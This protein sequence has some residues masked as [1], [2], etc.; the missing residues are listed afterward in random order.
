MSIDWN[1]TLI[2]CHRLGDIMTPA[3]NKGETLSQ[4]C[5]SYL[6]QLYRE[7][8]YNRR[9]SI[10]SKYI[11]KGL[12]VEED[13]ITLYARVKH[14]MY[15]KNEERLRNEF[16]TGEPDSYEGEEIRKATVIL[17][18]K[19]VWDLFTLPYPDDK[20]DS[21]YYWQGQGY[22]DLTGAEMFKLAYCL[23]DTPD[24]L[25]QKEIDSIRWR[26]GVEATQE[27]HEK[28]MKAMRYSDIPINERVVE[29]EI[30]HDDEAINKM[31]ERVFVCRDYL[32]FL[33]TPKIIS[34]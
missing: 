30:K 26:T 11:E 17:D 15:K 8:K 19:S 5:K 27:Q 4:T 3:K 7:K 21:G 12:H 34:V 22:M 13:S 10:I 23:V 20:I 28:I 6:R 1:Q 32:Q 18:T 29:F 14:R 25:I 9:K 33:D 24:F 16:V 2:R 31:H